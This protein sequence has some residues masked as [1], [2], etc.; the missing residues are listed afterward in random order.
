MA[1]EKTKRGYLIRRGPTVAET[2]FILPDD[3][4]KMKFADTEACADAEAIEELTEALKVA[5]KDMG[6]GEKRSFLKTFCKVD[7]FSDME[8]WSNHEVYALIGRVNKMVEMRDKM[9]KQGI[10]GGSHD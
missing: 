6:S 7:K 4:R 10:Q 3:A 9:G 5:C 2:G 1:Y 8:A